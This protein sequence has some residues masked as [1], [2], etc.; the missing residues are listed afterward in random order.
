MTECSSCYKPKSQLA[1]GICNSAICKS[2]A[3]FVS[4]DQFSFLQPLPAD[5]SH[6]TYCPTCF[7]SKVTDAISS[8]DQTMEQAKNIEVFYKKQSKET[9]FFSRLE[10]PLSIEDCA[11]YDEA[12]LRLAFRATQAG[13]NA[14][15]DLD[16]K[17]K[18]I[19][20]GRYQTS[21]WSGTAVPSHIDPSKIVHDRSIWQNPN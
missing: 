12:I 14:L 7:N 2:C 11:D 6:T 10:K 3:V 17:S 20:D 8:Y 18:K 21:S 5:L 1:C 4:E 19:R 15:I 9:R 13:F 16:L